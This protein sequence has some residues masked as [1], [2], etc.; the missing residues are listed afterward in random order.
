MKRIVLICALLAAFAAPVYA[1]VPPPKYTLVTTTAT[2]VVQA[3]TFY[4]VQSLAA[5]IT[6]VSCFDSATLSGTQI[7]ANT[8]TLTTLL[9]APAT[10][11]ALN[12]G[13]VTCA[14]ATSIVAPGYLILAR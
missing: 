4:G 7:Y 9:G 5:Q 13:F 6:V 3:T 8:P 11:M 14:I 1:D 12:S 2:T 10:G